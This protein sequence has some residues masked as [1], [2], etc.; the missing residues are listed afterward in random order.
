MHASFL[1]IGGGLSGL[2]AAI[3]LAR[4]NQNVFLL[5]KHSRLGG[6]NSYY[7]RNKQLLET[8]LHAVTNFAPKEIKNAPLNK[9]LRQLKINRRDL[10]IREQKTSRIQFANGACLS[11]SND[12][13]L[14]IDEIA[15]QF[16]DDTDNFIRLVDFLDNAD[17]FS[18]T[19]YISA[20]AV[21]REYLSSS[22]LVDMLLCPVLYYGSCWENDIDLN[23]FI[24]LFRS[25]FQE[26]L[27]RPGGSIKDIIDLLK[28]KYLDFGGTIKLNTGVKTILHD[29]SRAT[30]V[31]LENDEQLT[32]DYLIS[33]AGIDETRILL[34]LPPSTTETSR[35]SFTENIYLLKSKAA[36]KLPA[37]L[38][39]LFYNDS[40]TF[41]FK[42]RSKKSIS[43]AG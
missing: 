41:S 8:G 14:L 7:Y 3:R 38:T 31:V 33:T 37:D 23:Q 19:P 40:E 17:P 10:R 1:I 15:S 32:C 12:F 36:E 34:G 29:G 16:K 27:F 11:F 22:L 2:A 28:N 20:R 30:G 6:L 18:P 4:F 25:I 26:G 35:M 39:I 5:E 24:I 43:Q 13:R 9:L 42:N 21:L